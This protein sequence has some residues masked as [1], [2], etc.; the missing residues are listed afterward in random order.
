MLYPSSS[1]SRS[2]YSQFSTNDMN[3]SIKSDFARTP[4]QERTK[5]GIHLRPF[6]ID[7]DVL[8]DLEQINRDNGFIPCRGCGWDHD[9][10]NCPNQ[11]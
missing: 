7:Q 8:T 11:H 9:D 4:L 1:Q 3:N 6:E 2:F 5:Y 10:Y